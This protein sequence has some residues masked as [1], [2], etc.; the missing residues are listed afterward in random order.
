MTECA[1]SSPKLAKNFANGSHA[2]CLR[3][4]VASAKALKVQY[5]C[6]RERLSVRDARD[7]SII[8]QRWR[9]YF[10]APTVSAKE[11]QSVKVAVSALNLVLARSVELAAKQLTSACG[12]TEVHPLFAN[13]L[14][15]WHRCSCAPRH[16]TQNKPRKQTRERAGASL[17]N[18]RFHQSRRFK[19]NSNVKSVQESHLSQTR[20]QKTF[21]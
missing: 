12:C 10:E 3:A 21:E 9:C 2:I 14:W 18:T 13:F 19:Y 5:K 15:S 16:R 7:E 17:R 4:L 8:A 6:E 1:I 11:K 20:A